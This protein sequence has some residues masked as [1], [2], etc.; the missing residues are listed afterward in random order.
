[1][2]LL[3]L[4]RRCVRARRRSPASRS[5]PLAA[6]LV[7]GT[8]AWCALGSI[9]R[10]EEF[11]TDFTRCQCAIAKRSDDCSRQTANFT[12]R[13]FV[14]GPAAA[15]VAAHC[16]RLRKRL[17]G[18]VFDLDAATRWQPKCVV[19]L[20]ASRTSYARAVGA[21]GTQTVGSSNVSFAAGRITARRIDL[22]PADAD[23]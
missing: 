5:A 17:C 19:V 2:G 9:A 15:D 21:G 1:M 10:A 20:H 12:I 22:L 3:P 4:P 6:Y 16:E 11:Q 13:S 7:G 8:V 14:G 23:K 18:D